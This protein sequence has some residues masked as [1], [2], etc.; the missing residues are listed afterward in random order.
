M[1]VCSG[2]VVFSLSAAVTFHCFAIIPLSSRPPAPAQLVHNFHVNIALESQFSNEINS[3]VSSVCVLRSAPTRPT[4]QKR[5]HC[6]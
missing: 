1:D 3:T 4:Q 6:N 5:V 2:L